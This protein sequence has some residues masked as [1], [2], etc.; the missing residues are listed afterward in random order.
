SQPPVLP[1]ELLR[2]TSALTPEPRP[3]AHRLAATCR[4]RVKSENATHRGER[5]ATATHARALTAQPLAA[6][7]AS[8]PGSSDAAQAGLVRKTNAGLASAALVRLSPL[9]R[10]GQVG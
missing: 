4:I 10:S 8:Q 5:P 1:P 2:P 6:I 7:P 3:A 9:P